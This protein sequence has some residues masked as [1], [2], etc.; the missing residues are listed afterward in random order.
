MEASVYSSE[1]GSW[2]KH[3]V[4]LSLPN[5]IKI[6]KND[7]VYCNGAI[8]WL[9]L[10]EINTIHRAPLSLYFDINR[11]CVKN[12]P[13]LPFTLPYYFMDGAYFVECRG[14]LH[15]IAESSMQVKCYSI[16]ELKEDYSG[17]IQK[18]TLN[19]TT[20]Q[21]PVR[22]LC[23]VSQPPNEDEE[24][25]SMLAVLLVGNNYTVMSYNLKDHTSRIIYQEGRFYPDFF[26][27]P[28]FLGGQY[29]EILVSISPGSAMKIENEEEELNPSIMRWPVINIELILKFGL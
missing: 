22:S 14:N 21:R 7:G 9:V 19:L 12:L 5:D 10:R 26:A 6:L 27:G 11:L 28:Y 17:W 1:T 13:T 2:S 3:D 23:A 15:L 24:D 4:L 25:E 20:L 8:H 29:F 16:W 18:Y